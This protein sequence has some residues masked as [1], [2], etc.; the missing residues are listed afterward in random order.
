MRLQQIITDL[1]FNNPAM[2]NDY[3]RNHSCKFILNQQDKICIITYP[4][5]ETVE[6]FY[7]EEGGYCFL[8]AKE[9]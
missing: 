3:L 1:K 8:V 7:T 5:G 4:T 9:V 6:Y 2:L